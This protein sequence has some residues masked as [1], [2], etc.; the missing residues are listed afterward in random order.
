MPFTADKFGA[1]CDTVPPPPGNRHKS[2]VPW[3]VMLVQ[4]HYKYIRTLEANEPEELYDLSADPDEL[5]NL[6]REPEHAM[7][8]KDL[9]AAAIAELRRTGAKMAASLPPVG[10]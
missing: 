1:H 2:G 9:R 5:T 7:K 4:G 3:Y 6:A 8:L 10:E